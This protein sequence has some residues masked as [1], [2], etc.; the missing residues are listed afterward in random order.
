MMFVADKYS[1]ATGN[2]TVLNNTEKEVQN[3][4]VEILEEYDLQ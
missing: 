3:C 4:M 1:N 2:D